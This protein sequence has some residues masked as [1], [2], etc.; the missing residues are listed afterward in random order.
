MCRT[1]KIF[2]S[3]KLSTIHYSRNSYAPPEQFLTNAKNS[4]QKM[5]APFKN[6]D[7]GNMCIHRH[8]EVG[9]NAVTW[10]HGWK[11]LSNGGYR[12]R[13]SV[14]AIVLIT[15]AFRDIQ[16]TTANTEFIST[17]LSLGLE[18]F[19]YSIASLL[20]GHRTGREQKISK[21]CW[22]NC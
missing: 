7:S 11:W 2:T 4:K 16:Y 22:Q 12:R 18:Q 13:E 20:Q 5:K 21:L 6:I 10:V 15:C 1:S 3:G 9:R 8:N 19:G 17:D 14:K